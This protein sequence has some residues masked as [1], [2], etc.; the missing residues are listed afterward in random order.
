MNIKPDTPAP[1]L[2]I[3]AAGMGSRYGGLKQL[4][5][6]GPAGE[7]I[8]DYSI[9]DAAAAGFG[10]VIFVIRRDFETD[11]KARFSEKTAAGMETRYVFQAPRLP[12]QNPARTKPWGTGHAV[13]AAEKEIRGPFA[14]INA[15]DYYGAESFARMAQFLKTSCAPDR[16]GMVAWLLKNTVSENGAVSRGICRVNAQNELEEVVE[17]TH[18]RPS[19]E[20]RFYDERKNTHLPADA[21]VSMNFWGFHPAIFPLLRTQ[22]DAFTN[23]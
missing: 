13:L 7:T 21:R 20:G 22:F 16:F 5:A 6:V 9:Q 17:Y 12:G 18:I 23:T 8:M 19:G 4:A 14:V 10:R 2:V 1:D 15:D 3:L 11:F